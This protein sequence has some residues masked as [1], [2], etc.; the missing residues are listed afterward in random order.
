MATFGGEAYF[1]ARKGTPALARTP[2]FP[3]ATPVGSLP[4]L[5]QH[6]SRCPPTTA[7][8]PRATFRFEAMN[9]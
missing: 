6:S 8:D 9:S 5:S 7:L 4:A 3:E 2:V 1:G